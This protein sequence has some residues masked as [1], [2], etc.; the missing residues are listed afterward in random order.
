MLSHLQADT[1]I[2]VLWAWMFVTGLG[3]GPTFAVFTLIVQN[4]VPVARARHGH[5][6]PDLLPA[7]R[8]HGRPGPHRA[9]SSRR[10]SLTSCRASSR[11]PGSRRRSV[12]L[13]PSG[14]ARLADRRR[15]PRRGDPGG[16]PGRGSRGVRP[17]VPAIVEAIHE[18]LS[19]ATSNTFMLGIGA[20]VVAAG[21]VLLL[22]EAP[23][24][25]TE[26]ELGSDGR[27][28]LVA[29]DAVGDLNRR[30]AGASN[31]AS[32]LPRPVRSD[33]RS[34][35]RAQRVVR[36]ARHASALAALMQF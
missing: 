5:Q 4:S 26:P 2:P 24:A 17:F 12:A 25:A 3:V 10:V 23:A 36:A 22:R 8:R 11:R 15:R 28:R 13:W 21:L 6:Q 7:G 9:R 20:S 35:S 31:G 14:W 19:I 34:P 1:P 16:D 18:A 29:A 30:W 27:A 32:A 33:A